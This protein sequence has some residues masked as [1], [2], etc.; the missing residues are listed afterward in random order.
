MFILWFVT[1]LICLLSVLMIDRCKI[2]IG[3]DLSSKAQVERT[4]HLIIEILLL[5]ATF[6]LLTDNR[7]GVDIINYRNWYIR[8][9]TIAGREVLYTLLRNAAHSSGMSFYM[10]RALVS[11]VSGL[12]PVLI[13]RKE[14]LNI[15]FFLAI[16][17]PSLMFLDSMQFRNQVAICIVVLGSVILIKKDDIK[18]KIIFVLFVLIAM[19]FHTSAIMFLVFLPVCSKHKKIWDRVFLI[20]GILLLGVAFLN[21][22]TVP[23]INVLYSRILSSSDTR[24]YSYGSGHRI[25]LYPTAVH[26]ITTLLST[27]SVRHFNLDTTNGKQSLQYQYAQFINS[28]NRMFFVFVPFVLMHTTFYRLLR[29]IFVFNIISVGFCYQNCRSNNQRIVMFLGLLLI[30]VLWIIFAVFIYSSVEIIID[31]V[32]K[33]GILFF[34]PE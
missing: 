25:F 27:Y 18:H 22:R 33:N 5:T 11:F 14:K 17:L 7:T 15:A 4:S 31:P 1:F 20:V 9:E 10:F 21:N 34:M 32:L 29:N 26:I 23:L 3:G 12:I 8:N 6:L 28:A 30:S 2:T 19:Q 16:Y 13:M 24:L